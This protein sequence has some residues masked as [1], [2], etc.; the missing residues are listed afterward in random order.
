MNYNK[1]I[2]FGIYIFVF[3][4]PLLPYKIKISSIPVS[5]DLLV[6][7][8]LISVVILMIFNKYSRDKLVDGLKKIVQT[9]LFI[10]V[11]FYTLICLGTLFVAVSK[12]IVIMELTR[13]WTYILLFFIITTFIDKRKNIRDIV[14]VF[15]LSVTLSC[16]IGLM[17]YFGILKTLVDPATGIDTGKVYST[18]VNPNYWGAFIN[19]VLFPVLM[20]AIKKVKYYKFLYFLFLILFLN[21][22]MTGT[23]GSWIGFFMGI[24]L[25]IIIYNKKLIIPVIVITPFT[26]L[27][28][29]VWQRLISIFDP[30]S[31]TIVERF[32]LWK[33][34]YLM[35]KEHPILGVGNG[36]Y[37]IKYSEYI[38][39]YHE[40][41]LGREEYSVHNSYL[42]VLCETGILG[43]IPF[44]LII[45][46]YVKKIIDIYKKPIN[47]LSKDMAIAFLC[48]IVSYLFQNIS[49]N[50][51]FIPQINA[52]F[53]I[54]GAL[55]IT[56]NKIEDRVI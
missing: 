40:L 22:I 13:F 25:M 30:E 16:I 45:V 10:S 3:F 33:T 44:L 35:F 5:A 53:W 11:I 15:I 18:F 32:T 29:K 46:F 50:L 21:L 34:G 47:A 55:L 26:L 49:N 43:F 17:Q 51:F 37:L 28:P 4:V 27:I 48:S 24:L 20:L 7:L 8:Y 42:K 36:N 19:I 31:W 38:K 52:F 41:D 56:Y 39:R 12:T 9:K 14:G 2:L 6:I 23:R 54:I 1:A